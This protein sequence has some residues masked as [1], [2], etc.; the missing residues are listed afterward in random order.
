MAQGLK[1]TLQQCGV[2]GNRT[3][4]VPFPS[5]GH[6]DQMDVEFGR[7]ISRNRANTDIQSLRSNR[8]LRA[9]V[10]R[11]WW[12]CW[13]SDWRFKPHSLACSKGPANPVVPGWVLRLRR[14]AGR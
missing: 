9:Q 10:Y 1:R 7:P 4:A 5:V 6:A 14:G 2:R 12:C 13:M 11:L 8:P 3:S